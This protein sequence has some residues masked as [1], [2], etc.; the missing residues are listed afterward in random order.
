MNAE[1]CCFDCHNGVVDA[2]RIVDGCRFAFLCNCGAGA[3]RTER[4]PFYRGDLRGFRIVDPVWGPFPGVARAVK[5]EKLSS[6]IFLRV[7]AGG[8]GEW[9]IPL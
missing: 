3:R 9:A 7:L 6:K 1:N 8:R 2:E 5:N 4:Y